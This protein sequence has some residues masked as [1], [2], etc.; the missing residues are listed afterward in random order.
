MPNENGE[1]ILK[2]YWMRLKETPNKLIAEAYCK[3]PLPTHLR[4]ITV[5]EAYDEFLKSPTLP[6]NTKKRHH[7]G[8][9]LHQLEKYGNPMGIKLAELT[10]KSM[11][12][13][14][15]A[16]QKNASRS[17]I[18]SIW[19]PFIRTLKF[20]LDGPV[21]GLDRVDRAHQQ[22]MVDSEE[23]ITIQHQTTSIENA[24]DLVSKPLGRFAPVKERLKIELKKLARGRAYI[25]RP[26]IEATEKD[27]AGMKTSIY[28]FLTDSRLIE[29]YVMRFSQKKKVFAFFHREDLLPQGAKTN[30]TK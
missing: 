9:S 16:I 27:V 10:F 6:P 13:T 23:G 4:D 30:G 25:F 17:S 14:I 5:R 7:V 1:K 28:N 15:L 22:Q 18:E 21:A 2:N 3:N 19:Y 26:D 8:F 24:L 20:N 12:K 29:K 11:G